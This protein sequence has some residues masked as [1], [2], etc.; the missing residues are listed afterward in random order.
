MLAISSRVLVGAYF[1]GMSAS[2]ATARFQF[3]NLVLGF[4]LRALD[5]RVHANK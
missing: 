4:A 2:L 5:S 3:S 1:L